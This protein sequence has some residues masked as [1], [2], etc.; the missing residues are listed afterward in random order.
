MNPYVLMIVA[1]VFLSSVGG[2][3]IKGRVDGVALE[4]GEQAEFEISILA[5]RAA[6]LE[7]TAAAIS[8]IQVVNTTITQEVQREV[9]KEIVYRDCRHTPNGM[10]LL[11]DALAGVLTPGDIELPGVNTLGR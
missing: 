8:G 9:T 6:A 2:S 5:T 3:Y 10:R 1:L 4:K 11:Q 7:A